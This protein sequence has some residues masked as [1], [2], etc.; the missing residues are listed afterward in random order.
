MADTRVDARN[1][2]TGLSR[3]AQTNERG[4]YRIDFVPPGNYE[5]EVARPGFRTFRQTGITLQVGQFARV[6]VVP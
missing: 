6:D 5:L 2:E 1:L 4:E 3:S